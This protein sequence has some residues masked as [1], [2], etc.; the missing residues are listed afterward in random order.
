MVILV[1]PTSFIS[2]NVVQERCGILEDNV[3][4]LIRSSC[5]MSFYEL[6]EKR[7]AQD[8]ALGEEQLR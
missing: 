2:V 7:P 4:I 1:Q 5:E 6:L 8:G 3:A